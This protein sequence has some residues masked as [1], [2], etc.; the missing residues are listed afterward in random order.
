LP[1]YVSLTTF[2]TVSVTTTDNEMHWTMCGCVRTK[3]A[4]CRR[5]EI[6]EV[7][8]LG[9]S[10]SAGTWRHTLGMSTALDDAAATS[11][12]LSEVAIYQRRC[13]FDVHV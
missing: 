6:P 2:I 4:N 10:T 3:L 13:S 8:R 5:R 12:L 1:G 7:G 9:G 11:W